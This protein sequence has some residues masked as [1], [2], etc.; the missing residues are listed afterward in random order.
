MELRANNP[1][2]TQAIARLIDNADDMHLVWPK[3]RWP[4][5]PSQWR[6]ALDPASGHHPFLLYEQRRIIGHAALRATR[7]KS[8]YTVN[9]LYLQSRYRSQGRGR[10]VMTMLEKYAGERLAAQQLNL[11]VRTYNSRAMACYHKCGFKAAF[12]EGSLI[13][14][15][16][17][18][19]R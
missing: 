4:F 12:R 1:L 9:Y 5:D 8:I 14:M 6:R 15:T 13:H 3:A 2:D 18:L 16:K 10:T 11:V 17:F 19:N 7:S